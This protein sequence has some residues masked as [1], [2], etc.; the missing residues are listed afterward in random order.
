MVGDHFCGGRPEGL[1]IG[2]DSRRSLHDRNHYRH[3]WHIL[4]LGQVEARRGA[5]KRIR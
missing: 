1:G 3:G 2:V 5:G 4:R